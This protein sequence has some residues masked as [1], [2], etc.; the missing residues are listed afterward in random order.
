MSQAVKT[1]E[2]ATSPSKIYLPTD[3]SNSRVIRIKIVICVPRNAWSTC[4]KCCFLHH[5]CGNSGILSTVTVTEPYHD[6]RNA[7]VRS[8]RYTNASRMIK[9]V[10]NFD[11]IIS[12][13]R[14]T[15][16]HKEEEWFPDWAVG[17][18]RA[19]SRFLDLY[20]VIWYLVVGHQSLRLPVC[21]LHSRTFR[22][23]LDGSIESRH[24]FSAIS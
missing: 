13:S 17:S 24:A 19:F 6:K 20:Q 15:L 10:S 14:H 18:R 9:L 3:N 5:H 21:S 4:G 12:A 8:K 16:L 1:Q 22:M 2:L 23:N 11:F 7:I